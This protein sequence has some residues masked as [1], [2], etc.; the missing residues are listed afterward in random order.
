LH[1]IARACYTHTLIVIDGWLLFSP[2][3]QS[4]QVVPSLCRAVGVEEYCEARMAD[5][6]SR[7]RAAA[8]KALKD[9]GKVIE[10]DEDV[11]SMA[12]EEGGDDDDES[13]PP[14]DASEAKEI[15]DIVNCAFFGVLDS[16]TL[17]ESGGEAGVREAK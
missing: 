9:I 8:R 14:T 2:F 15:P 17:V 1:A 10:E 12:G 11:A 16:I 7:A 4:I 6:R 3:L 13:E 5:V